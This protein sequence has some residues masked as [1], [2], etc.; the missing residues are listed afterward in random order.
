MKLKFL[1]LFAC[2]FTVVGARA[3]T[4]EPLPGLDAYVQKVMTQWQVPGL[5]IAVVQD[6]KVVLARGYGVRELGKPDKVDADTLFDI[7]SNTKAFTAAALGTLVDSGKL[8]WDA[9]VVDHIQGFRLSDAYVTQSLTLRDL[10]TH[11]SGYCDPGSMW[12]TSDDSN[13]IERL[14]YQKP[15]SG[16]R[17]AFCYN[18]TLFLTAGRFIPAVTGESW[19]AYVA[20]KL[21]KPLGMDR[22]VTTGAALAASS[23]VAAPHALVDGKVTLIH[24]YWPHNMDIDAPV[25]GINSSA[26]DMSHWLLMLLAGGKYDGKEVLPSAVLEAMETPQVLIKA[27]NESGKILRFWMP[28][29]TFYTYGLGFFI[30]DYADHKLVWHAGDIDG[31]ASSLALVPDAHLGVVVLSNLDHSDARFAILQH[32]LQ[33][34]LGLPLQ[35]TSDSLYA[36]TQKALKAGEAQEQKLAATRKPG[37]SPTLSLKSY[38]GLYKDDFNGSARVTEENG[39]LVLRLE[40]PDFTGD[41]E[42][43]HDNTFRV[44]WRY[45]FYG[46][47][48]LTFDLDAYGKPKTM[49]TTDPTFHFERVEESAGADKH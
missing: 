8:S 12:Y 7:A 6:G 35:D 34:G 40:D 41:L 17:S 45:R 2:C 36:A 4:P 24:D 33:L 10:L 28:G 48:Y 26:D 30:Q 32:I 20:A 37:A 9:R 18:N 21:F 39:H 23:D 44:T 43:W 42:P 47:D 49:N 1:L 16:F 14:Q 15:D 19:N 31:M 46:K 25:G 13:V 11:D 38:A 29:G 5:A 22:S 27:D 3:D